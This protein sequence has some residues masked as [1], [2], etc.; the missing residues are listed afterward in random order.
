MKRLLDCSLLLVM[1]LV[2]VALLG[3]ASSLAHAQT[4]DVH[5]LEANAADHLG[6]PAIV[7]GRLQSAGGGHLQLLG[8]TIDCRYT[9]SR[10]PI[11]PGTTHVELEGKLG[12]ERSQL[13]FQIDALRSIPDE[14]AEFA[15]RRQKIP[16][17]KF[18]ALY[19]LSRWARARAK[20]YDDA[21]L[22]QLATSSYREAFRWEED[23]L[24]KSNSVAEL[25]ALA[26]RGEQLGL[27]VD[28]VQ[29]I[30]YRA[31]VLRRS[32]LPKDD[33]PG[34]QSLADDV[35]RL[36]PGAGQP[37]AATAK[38]LDQKSVDELIN[39]YAAADG[40][41]RAALQRGLWASAVTHALDIKAEDPATNLL[42]LAKQAAQL[43]PEDPEAARRLE[44]AA[45]RRESAHPEKLSREALVATHAGLV[46]LA[47]PDEARALVERWLRCRRDRLPKDEAEDRIQLAEDCLELANDRRQAAELYREAW[48]IVPD[49]AAAADGLRRLG[50]ELVGGTWRDAQE[51]GSSSTETESF[52]RPGVSETEVVRRLRRPDRVTRTAT[53]R[54]IIEQWTYAGPPAL[55]VYLRRDAAGGVAAV[56]RVTQVD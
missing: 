14:A 13:V 12:R 49:F 56:T 6:K 34:W 19:E 28:D 26:D 39:E 11:R 53:R 18:S 52:L 2:L 30:R 27:E 7:R 35:Q 25:L 24:A 8:S 4:L 36:L 5:E 48:S 50:F 44:L 17:G 51:L 31:L 16:D 21:R 37:P 41:A 33:R 32:K 3:G 23:F 45:W 43:L 1:A 20:W 40:P 22:R 9:E 55:V 54:G 46:R 29:R 15:A 47:Q 10:V 42:E 38:A